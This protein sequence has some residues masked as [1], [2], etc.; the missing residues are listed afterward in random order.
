VTTTFFQPEHADDGHYTKGGFMPARDLPARASLEH[1]KHEAKALH[2]AIQQG[3]AGAVARLRAALGE[4]RGPFKL[5]DAQRA[6]AREY[7]FPTWAR[8]RAHVQA[9]QGFDEAVAAFL[10]AVQENDVARAREVLDANPTIATES[11]HVAA[12]LGAS[13]DVERLIAEDPSRLRLRAGRFGG[14]ALLC[15]CFSPFHGESRERDDGL[16]ATVQLLV[17]AGADPNTRETVFGL[18]ALFAVTGQRS[19]IP[20]ARLLLDAGANPTDG[21][22]LHHA[23]EKFHED[24]LELLLA[25]GADLDG[26][27]DWGNTPLYFLVRWY[28]LQRHERVRRGVIWLLEHG[29]GPNLPCGEDRETP[30]H[31]AARLGQ[32]PSAVELLVEHG[33]DVRARRG[34]G[35]TPWRLAAR[36]GFDTIASVLESAGADREPLSPAEV[37]LAA[38]GR[39]DSMAAR[40]L[41][42]PELV[43][44]ITADDLR[45]LPL[46]ASMSRDATV[47]ACVA[48][49]LPVDALDENGATALHYSAIHGRA[50]AVRALLTAGART[51]IVD[52]EHSSTALGWACYGSDM[53]NDADGDYPSCVR[54][55]VAAGARFTGR[56]YRPRRADVRGELERAGMI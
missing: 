27:G 6:I 45:M 24:A 38:C 47:L 53:V 7:G 56:E 50:D 16:R 17:A 12:A 13:T 10:D 9:S 33:A 19:V 37:L 31:V 32:H 40:A 3:S 39:G 1:L 2:R 15:A 46:A 54:A 34:D 8:L 30:L 26:K 4:A 29:A 43:Q 11:V 42:S 35:R 20:I 48:A 44:S 5:T 22:S 23:A 49:G 51:D 21:E 14:D 36:N 25:A 55:L 41:S 18:P 52:G 28:D